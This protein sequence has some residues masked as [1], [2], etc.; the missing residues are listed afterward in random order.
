MCINLK[1]GERGV[2]VSI[3]MWNNH[4]ILTSLIVSKI[5]ILTPV[6]PPLLQWKRG[7]SRCGR[8]VNVLQIVL[9][10]THS[11]VE[12]IPRRVLQQSQFLRFDPLPQVW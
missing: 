3:T 4:M 11:D 10:T 9:V 1:N 7:I 6:R 12:M 2:Y 8:N 5:P